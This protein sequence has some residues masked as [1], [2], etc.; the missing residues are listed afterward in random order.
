MKHGN[1]GKNFFIAANAFF[2]S[3]SLLKKSQKNSF[4]DRFSPTLVVEKWCP[5]LYTLRT[6]SYDNMD[7]VGMD[8]RWEVFGPFHDYLLHAFPRVYV[9]PT[10]SHRVFIK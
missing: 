4:G 6:E 5:A 9:V 8:P 1:R 10:R 2:W 7:P 3:V